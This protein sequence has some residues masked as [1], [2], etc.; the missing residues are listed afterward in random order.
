MSPSSVL[1]ARKAARADK[2]QQDD[3]LRALHERALALMSDGVRGPSVMARAQ[4]AIAKRESARTCSPFYI[5]EWRRILVNPVGGLRLHV[6]QPD[7]PNGITLM[8]NTPFG[9]LLRE[10]ALA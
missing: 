3:D 6:L 5:A 8:H 10:P 1:D 2:H 9:F 7:A 4:T